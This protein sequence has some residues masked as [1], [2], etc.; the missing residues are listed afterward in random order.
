VKHFLNSSGFNAAKNLQNVFLQGT[1]TSY[2]KYSLKNSN[3]SFPNVT[4]SLQ[5]SAP[6][7]DPQILINKI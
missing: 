1:P 5:L 7:I 4:K 6:Q 2:G 3:F